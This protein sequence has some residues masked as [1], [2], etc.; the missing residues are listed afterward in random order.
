MV[1]TRA[2]NSV[3]PARI[4]IFPTVPATTVELTD[5]SVGSGQ[6]SIRITSSIT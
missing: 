6:S 2:P 1:H 5:S 3:A 4:A